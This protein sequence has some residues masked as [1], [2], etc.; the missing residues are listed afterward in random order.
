MSKTIIQLAIKSRKTSSREVVA[1]KKSHLIYHHKYHR[2]ISRNIIRPKNKS[3]C[4]VLCQKSPSPCV[5][6]CFDKKKP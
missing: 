3:M 4:G 1:K 2:C 6:R 5:E